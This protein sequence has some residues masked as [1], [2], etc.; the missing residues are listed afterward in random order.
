MESIRQML[1]SGEM[2]IGV[3]GATLVVIIV[4]AFKLGS[5]IKALKTDIKSN[6]DLGISNSERISR[7]EIVNEDMGKEHNL[8]KITQAV[9]ETKLENIEAGMVEIKVLL[10]KKK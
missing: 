10:M 8:I 3:S 7:V 4:V 2:L 1:I 9:L 6:A 5:Y